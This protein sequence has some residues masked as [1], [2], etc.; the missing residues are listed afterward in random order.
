MKRLILFINLTF[1]TVLAFSQANV[2]TSIEGLIPPAPT[3]AA[4]GEYNDIPVNGY[5]GLP[6]IGVPIHQVSYNG[7]TIPIDLSYHANGIKVSEEASWV[8]L[9]WSLNAGGVISRTI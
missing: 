3:A 5:T 2:P 1:S 9:G 6:S 4:L 8:G 7:I